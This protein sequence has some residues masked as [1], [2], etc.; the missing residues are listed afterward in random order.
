MAYI[1][2][3]IGPEEKLVG[4][5]RLHWIYILKGVL[6]FLVCALFGWA[7]NT[8]TLMLLAAVTRSA[9][10]ENSVIPY[11][12]INGWIMPIFLTFGII[13]FALYLVKVISTEIG[14]SNKRVIHKNGL[15][16]VDVHEIDIEEIRGE[17]LNLGVFGRILGYGYI[18][19]DCRFIGDIQLPAMEQPER[20]LRA[21]HDVRA[22]SMD[23]LTMVMGKGKGVGVNIQESPEQPPHLDMMPPPELTQEEQQRIIAQYQ[24]EQQRQQLQQQQ[25]QLPPHLKQIQQAVPPQHH[26]V[27]PGESIHQAV[28][29]DLEHGPD[30]PEQPQ[31]PTPASEAQTPKPPSNYRALGHSPDLPSSAQDAATASAPPA[32]MAKQ[33]LAQPVENP[34]SPPV[35]DP[36]TV[37][38]IVEQV[39]PQ[40]IEKVVEKTIAPAGGETMPGEKKAPRMTA[41]MKAEGLRAQPPLEKAEVPLEEELLVSF[42]EASTAPVNGHEHPKPEPEQVMP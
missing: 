10:P 16:F 22:Q 7:I 37:A 25:R 34:D 41:K 26:R 3:I 29:D 4:I 36:A 18:L 14:L 6:W 35:V 19:L 33:P 24:Q 17:R 27:V 1:K 5:A 2:R 32:Q 31:A 38:Q 30:I 39:V 13:L 21:L 8:G 42:D 28:M 12:V 23:T 9:E 11:A 20:F 15:I 40:I